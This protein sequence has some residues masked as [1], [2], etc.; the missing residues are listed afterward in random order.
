[1]NQTIHLTTEYMQQAYD[2]MTYVRDHL[3]EQQKHFL[4]AKSLAELFAHHS[5]E[6]LMLGIKTPSGQIVSLLI[7]QPSGIPSITPHFNFGNGTALVQSVC[8]HP[9]YAGKSLIDDLFMHLNDWA[10]HHK[11]VT[12]LHAKISFANSKSIQAFLKKGF[13][14]VHA[15]S[16]PAQNY[17]A[18]V[19]QK[20][21]HPLAQTVLFPSNT[22]H[23]LA[24][25]STG[26]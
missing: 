1:M 8:I 22:L 10:L 21:I 12:H 14:L 5:R 4:R 18:V 20:E 23:G 11:A 19:V 7:A 2:L 6:D 9:D 15:G 26:Y 25:S 24:I 3:P 13:S 16:D 17:G